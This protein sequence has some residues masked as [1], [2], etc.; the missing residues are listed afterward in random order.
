MFDTYGKTTSTTISYEE[1]NKEI[2]TISS[3]VKYL[4]ARKKNLK[5]RKNS[6]LDKVNRRKKTEPIRLLI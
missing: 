4:S 3:L 6:I 2:I 1:F 5:V